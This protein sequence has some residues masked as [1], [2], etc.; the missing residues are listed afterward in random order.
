[1]PT[2]NRQV[3]GQFKAFTTFRETKPVG[4]GKAKLFYVSAFM[5][6]N[7]IVPFELIKILW[8]I[9]VMNLSKAA[10][11]HEP[12]ALDYNFYKTLTLIAVQNFVFL[13]LSHE[14]QFAWIKKYS[15]DV[16]VSILNM[17]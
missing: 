6:V 13:T 4:R 2:H 17:L 12:G 9:I 8:R 15:S 7:K 5:H 3:N 14:K 10:V 16:F 11:Q 1:M